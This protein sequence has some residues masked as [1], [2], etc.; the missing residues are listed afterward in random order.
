MQ[1]R[2]CYDIALAF[3][4]TG[5]LCLTAGTV[6]GYSPDGVLRIATAT[7]LIGPAIV[8]AWLTTRRI[9]IG[10]DQASRSAAEMA[11]Q[12]DPSYGSADTALGTLANLHRE[13]AR[14]IADLREEQA[15]AERDLGASASLLQAA[16]AALSDAL[17]V[18]D[19]SG[20]LVLM[21]PAAGPILDLREGLLNRPLVEVVR[22]PRLLDLLRDATTSG[23]TASDV[24]EL[25]RSGRSMSVVVSPLP[26]PPGG[27]VIL[28]QDET[29]L[30][31]LER[32]RSDFVNNVSHELKTPV[33]SIQAYADTLR[34][35]GFDD[36]EMAN[37]FLDRIISQSSRLGEMI[38]DMLDLSRMESPEVEVEVADVNLASVV[39]WVLDDHAQ[40]AEKSG[41]QIVSH[42]GESAA[43][44][45]EEESLKVLLN[46]LVKNGIEHTPHGG[47]VEL[48][49]DQQFPDAHREHFDEF[50]QLDLAG[51]VCIH[52]RDT[53]EG[54]SREHQRRIFER[55]FRVD[56]SRN[57]Q[58]GGSGLGLSIVKHTAERFGGH[59]S[60]EATIG[61]GSAFHVSLP[62]RLGKVGEVVGEP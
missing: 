27:A 55:F 51:Y 61:K 21:N 32:M 3:I 58:L 56:K 23:N 49:V 2:Q 15:R 45:G 29:E 22:M 7:T 17:L 20:R 9:R 37:Q 25:T 8:L 12:S 34:Q 33:T 4:A 13:V 59:V 19:A 10:L 35:G 50:E 40:V 54:I 26:N 44:R 16:Y 30:R 60:V 62:G 14:R 57:R 24:V 6:F 52:V 38:V 5:S 36:E 42:V 1:S 11:Q 46:N 53:G 41:V 43:V 31:R 39:S 18:V 48:T 28:V 47:S